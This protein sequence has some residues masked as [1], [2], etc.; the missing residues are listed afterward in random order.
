MPLQL[1]PTTPGSDAAPEA[2]HARSGVRFAPRDRQNMK[3]RQ[4]LGFAIEVQVRHIE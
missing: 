3:A 1:L 2:R 4:A